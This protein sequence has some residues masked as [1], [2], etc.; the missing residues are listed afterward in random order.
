MSYL[1]YALRSEPQAERTYRFPAG[2]PQHERGDEARLD[3][4]A[5]GWPGAKCEGRHRGRC[6]V[7]WRSSILCSVLHTEHF[8]E[9][10][11]PD[12]LRKLTEAQPPRPLRASVGA[13]AASGA[14]IATPA[15]V[16]AR[17]RF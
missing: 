16:A 2:C 1:D 3:F 7:V 12:Q 4:L 14:A 13:P 8:C 6:I 10:A 17:V 9:R 15:G 5:T 11:L